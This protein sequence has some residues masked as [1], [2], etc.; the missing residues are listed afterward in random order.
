[1]LF[2][3]HRVALLLLDYSNSG[4]KYQQQV[5]IISEEQKPRRHAR[6]SSWM[7]HLAEIWWPYQN[8]SGFGVLVGLQ[9]W[10]SGR[11]ETEWIRI[12]EET[13]RISLILTG[14][15]GS[16]ESNEF[17]GIANAEQKTPNCE[18]QYGASSWSA[19]VLAIWCGH[20]RL[21]DSNFQK[22]EIY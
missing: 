11:V 6:W 15:R 14:S 10:S 22:P 20:I 8:L 19:T 21:N 12:V 4:V 16:T 17:H 9:V 5:L 2:S 13:I 7:I 18:S 1:M 3:R